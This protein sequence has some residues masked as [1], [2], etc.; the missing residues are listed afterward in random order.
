MRFDDHPDIQL[1]EPGQCTDSLYGKDCNGIGI[2]TTDPFAEEI[3]GEVIWDY[4][5]DGELTGRAMD[6]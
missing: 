6:I 3:Y 5:C 1:H 4:Y 2:W